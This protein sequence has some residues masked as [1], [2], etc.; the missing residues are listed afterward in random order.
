MPDLIQ[1]L[2]AAF[3]FKRVPTDLND[4]GAAFAGFLN[5]A[6][7]DSEA[8]R[9]LQAQWFAESGRVRRLDGAASVE[10]TGEFIDWLIANQW[11]EDGAADPAP[12]T[13]H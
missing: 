8:A 4:G 1:T 6:S 5:F 3:G 12:V 11:G 10:D 9:N 7:G 13:A 2:R